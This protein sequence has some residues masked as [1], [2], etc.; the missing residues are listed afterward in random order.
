[1]PAPTKRSKGMKGKKNAQ[2]PLHAAMDVDDEQAASP[3]GTHAA[4]GDSAAGSSPPPRSLTAH[5]FVLVPSLCPCVGARIVALLARPL[6]PAHLHA[7]LHDCL[8]RA[9]VLRADRL[10]LEQ[11]GGARTTGKRKAAPEPQ[12]DSD[13]DSDAD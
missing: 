2:R 5:N 4:A 7:H 9:Q 13:A 1:M 10:V 12:P 11:Q 3:S 8:A 6:S